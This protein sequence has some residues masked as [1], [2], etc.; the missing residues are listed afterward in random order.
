MYFFLGLL[1]ASLYFLQEPNSFY[2]SPTRNKVDQALLPT[3]Y[4]PYTSVSSI[5]LQQQQQQRPLTGAGTNKKR[6]QK[7]TKSLGQYEFKSVALSSDMSQVQ[8][9]LAVL[10]KK[11]DIELD[12][13]KSE[14]GKEVDK[15]HGGWLSNEFC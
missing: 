15:S 12:S 7:Q 8:E 13:V 14:S 5:E 6:L 3:G 2:E 1:T 11:A 10:D 4:C 9:R